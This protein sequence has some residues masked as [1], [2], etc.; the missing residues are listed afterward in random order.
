MSSRKSFNRSV[1]LK[2]EEE[3]ACLSQGLQAHTSC[4]W[5]QPALL[6]IYYKVIHWPSNI[7]EIPQQPKSQRQLR[8]EDSV[9]ASSL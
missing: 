9:T 1:G 7:R 4:V 6:Q 5:V 8:P 3:E 2:P